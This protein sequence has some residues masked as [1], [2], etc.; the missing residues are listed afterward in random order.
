MKRELKGI[1]NSGNKETIKRQK[2]ERYAEAHQRDI[3]A[4]RDTP[5]GNSDSF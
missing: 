3:K 4:Q 5:P 2:R 1:E